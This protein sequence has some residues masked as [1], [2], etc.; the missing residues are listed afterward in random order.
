MTGES[1]TESLR[2]PAGVRELMQDFASVDQD[3]DGR[4]DYQEF[5]ALM[6]ALQAD[7]SEDELRIGFHEIDADRDGRID[8]REFIDWWRSD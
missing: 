7:M 5:K 4:I 6:V 8:A 2:H 1:K 3:H